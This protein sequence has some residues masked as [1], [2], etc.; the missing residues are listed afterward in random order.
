M[1]YV[2]WIFLILLI[3]VRF[4]ATRPKYREGDKIRI[5]AALLSQPIKYST[6]QYLKISGLKIYL[7]S[8]PEINYGD[9]IIVEGEVDD[10]KLKDP[11]L[12]EIKRTNN[13]LYNLRTRLISFYKSN[14][15]EPHS[16][17]IAGV[18]VG[19]KE[20]IPRDFW[21]KLKN[22]GVAHVVVASGMNVTLVGGFLLNTFVN[23]V[24]RRK[25][26]LVSILGIWIYT[27]ISGFD[28]PLVRAAIMGTIAFSAQ[29][30]GRV[31][32]TLRALFL[33]AILM[34][35]FNPNWLID[36]GFILSFA[37]TLSL[38]L[39][40]KKIDRLLH[41]VPGIFRQDLAVT[42]SAQIGVAPIL[43][44]AFGQFNPLSPF[45]NVLV[46]WTIPLITIIGF[47]GGI[48]GLIVPEVGRLILFLA[49]PMTLWFNFIASI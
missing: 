27:L 39:F 38:I 36:L 46:L 48:F 17:L 34:L 1:K 9:K 47:I 42:I 32:F 14:I 22:K 43:Y 7:P 11:K 28:A 31:N 25:A 29:E 40:G 8:Y 4:T 33:S 35:I 18:V 19:S 41:F 5:S 44:F 37:A 21:E 10:D 12:I 45:I 30:F 13:F 26:L 3:L 20:S 16:S 49:Y 2:F 15:P 24:S 6:S 23:L